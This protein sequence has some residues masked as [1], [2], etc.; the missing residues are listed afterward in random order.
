MLA[1]CRILNVLKGGGYERLNNIA[2]RSRQAQCQVL[3]L[4]IF[5]GDLGFN[6]SVWILKVGF[7]YTTR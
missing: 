2:S 6:H 1:S 4:A 5:V 3:I 7:A